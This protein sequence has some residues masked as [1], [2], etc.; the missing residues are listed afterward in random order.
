MDD[1]RYQRAKRRMEAEKGFYIHL[2]VY[3]AVNTGL[4]LINFVGG[5]GEGNW[6]FVWPLAGWGIAVV[7][8][9]LSVFVFSGALGP[10]WEERR[11]REL[12]DKDQGQPGPAGDDRR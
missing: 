3:A 7:V 9:G 5:R 8:H 6:W 11:I 12:M 10:R 2:F 1:E 4:F